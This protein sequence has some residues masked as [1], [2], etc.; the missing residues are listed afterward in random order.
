MAA[1]GGVG[2]PRESADI[3]D[4]PRRKRLDSRREDDKGEGLGEVP[5]ARGF[6]ISGLSQTL[7]L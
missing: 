3:R 4:R 5:G 1:R 2:L 6:S 7:S